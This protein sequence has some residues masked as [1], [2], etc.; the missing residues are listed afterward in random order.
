MSKYKK[1]LITGAGGFIGSHVVEAAKEKGLEVRATDLS[2]TLETDHPIRK[3]NAMAAKKAADEVLPGDITNPDDVKKM[4]RGVDAIIHVASVFSYTTPWDILYKVNVEGTRQ[5]LNAASAEGVKRV[6]AIGAGGVY[7]IPMKMPIT[8]ED[9]PNPPNAYLRSKW[10]EEWL[11]MISAKKLGYSYAILRPTTVYGPRQSYGGVQILELGANNKVVSIP[12]NFTA[13]VPFIHVRDV[14]GAAV[15]VL[16]AKKTSNEIFNV[17]DDSQYTTI[18]VARLMAAAFNRPFMLLPP[19][20]INPIKDILQFV[21]GID[22][23]VAKK[24][25]KKMTNLEKDMLGLFGEDFV[26]S[27]EKLKATGYKFLYPDPKKGL[28]E[29][30]QW[31]KEVGIFK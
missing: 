27:N 23:M 5:L 13:R 12:S 19:V 17:N 15:H 3:Y 7:G 29:T 10:F 4:V 28:L 31:Y 18:E 21:A 2:A 16:D 9:P 22:D 26:Y 20:P 25:G 30:I 11:V 14:A 6:V 24:V 8:E 1:V